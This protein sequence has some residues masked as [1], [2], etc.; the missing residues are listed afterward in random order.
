[1]RP[2]PFG[3]VDAHV[4]FPAWRRRPTPP[5]AVAA[6]SREL[7]RRA[8][9]TW[10]FPEPEEEE[11]ASEAELA[12]RWA[13]EVERHGLERVLFVTGSSNDN[14]AAVVR[15]YPDRFAALAYHEPTRPDAR[16]EL[17][18]AVEELGFHGYKLIAPRLSLPFEDP[19]LRPLWEYLAEKRLPLLVH[20]GILGGGG[21]LGYHPRMD[22]RSIHDVA[23]DF[24]EMPIVVPHFGAGY[25]Q[26]LLHLGWTCPNVHV[27]TSGS[28]DWVRWSAYPLDLESLFRK[29]YETF[30]P[31]RIIFGT[32]SSWFP[33]GFSLRYLEDQ[34]RVCRYLRLPEADL[35]LIF[36]GNARRLYRL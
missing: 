13:Q 20:F 7:H 2:Q 4:H 29:A 5:P 21:G 10:G 19:S 14:L 16:R 26:E 6:Y 8:R 31:E 27:D 23:R 17:A 25:W 15:A 30:G 9:E 12:R 32:D 34:L 1:M 33:R 36:G 35:A 24:P 22:P 28:N 18:H 3:V 11:G